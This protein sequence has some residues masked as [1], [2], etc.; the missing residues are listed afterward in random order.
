MFQQSVGLS[1]PA[2]SVWHPTDNRRW[3]AI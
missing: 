1:R 3:G 2:L